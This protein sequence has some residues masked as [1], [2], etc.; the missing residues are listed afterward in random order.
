[1]LL[2]AFIFALILGFVFAAPG[3]VYIAGNI[4]EE[5]NGKISI[6]GPLVNVIFASIFLPCALLFSGLWYN[7]VL[8]QIVFYIYYINAFLAVFN[9]IPVMPLDG[10]KVQKWS[11]PIYVGI[12]GIAIVLLIPAFLLF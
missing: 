7:P 3:A 9:L 2:M 11:T 4:N 12:F 8:F 5:Q 6:A 10:A 1:M